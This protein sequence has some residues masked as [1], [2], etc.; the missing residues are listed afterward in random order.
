MN[1]I[2]SCFYK[3]IATFYLQDVYVI[4]ICKLRCFQFV[5]QT[6]VCGNNLSIHKTEN[7]IKRLNQDIFKG[8]NKAMA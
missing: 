3:I 1:L 7:K 6:E 5:K 8:C 4:Q 2:I